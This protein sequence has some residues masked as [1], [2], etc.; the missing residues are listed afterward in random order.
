MVNSIFYEKPLQSDYDSFAVYAFLGAAALA[1]V[2]VL[3]YKNFHINLTVDHCPEDPN[4]PDYSPS[5]VSS[6][7]DSSEDEEE[8]KVERESRLEQTKEDRH[9]VDCFRPKAPQQNP[10]LIRTGVNYLYKSRG[11]IGF[12]AISSFAAVALSQWAGYL[13]K[14]FPMSVGFEEGKREAL[15]NFYQ[16][17]VFPLADPT[18]QSSDGFTLNGV[19][20]EIFQKGCEG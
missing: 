19:F 3:A 17:Q 6:D 7:E 8:L 15:C 18:I 14:D 16:K 20:S 13:F 10:S 4:D 11:L 1:G 12:F 2:C 9:L 5:E